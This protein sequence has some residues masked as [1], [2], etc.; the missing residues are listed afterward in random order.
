M[1]LLNDIKKAFEKAENIVLIPHM[2]ADGDATGSCF[3]LS[4][5]LKKFKKKVS[6]I[7]EEYPWLTS[8]VQCEYDIY[9][10]DN[11]DYDLAVAVDCADIGRMGQ[12]AALFKG[13]TICI[14]HH[15]TNGSIA[16]IN[17]V[18]ADS[19]AT[20]ELV[21]EIINYIA[22]GF[23]DKKIAECLYMAISADTGC[24]KY[25]NVTS[26]TH[27]IVSAL[28]KTGGEFAVIN[29]KLFDTVPLKKMKFQSKIADGIEFYADGK[30]GLYYLSHEMFA[31]MELTLGDVE[32]VSGLIKTIEGVG[33]GVFIH[34]RLPEEYKV[35][36]RSDESA[37]VSEIASVFGGG[38]HARAA[39]FMISGCADN[40]KDN[41]VNTIRDN[42]V[43]LR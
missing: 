17:Y 9:N 24:F 40:V 35:S 8:V 32:F 30:I 5:F 18:E 19:A 28:Y 14:D 7:F 25:S 3:A 23:M 13:N 10:G 20:G 26:R 34:E 36:L 42:M 39:G 21:F 12:R 37:D 31:A 22:P 27:K 41:I 6:V 33:V 11:G 29:R 2:N 15:K 16:D 1:D 43:I 4:E 38:G